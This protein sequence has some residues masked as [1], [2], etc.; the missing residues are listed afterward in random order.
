MTWKLLG[1]LALCAGVLANAGMAQMVTE[2]AGHRPGKA[3][4]GHMHMHMHGPV[5]LMGRHLMPEGKV[6]LGLQAGHMKMSGLR[7]GSTDIAATTLVT[8][9]P[10][11]FAGMPGQPPTLRVAPLWM[12][13][14]MLMLGAMYGATDKVT[15]MMMMPYIR[16]EMASLTYTGPA[17]TVP[18]G[19]SRMSAEGFGDLRIGAMTG[20]YEK[21][22][23][24]AVAGLGL[25][26]PTGSITKTGPML[27]PGGM[28]MVRR[29]G[30]GMQLGSGTYDLLPQ[31]SFQTG[32]GALNWGAHLSGV[33]RL[34]DNDEGY[35]LGN[36]AA[37]NLWASYKP[38]GWIDYTA[39]LETKT[40]D[41]IHGIDPAIVM[42]TPGAD[43]RNFG[44]E[45]VAL[46]L[47]TN[48]GPA[49]GIAKGHKI[50]LEIG[51]PVHQR[52]N[53]PRLKQD[54]SLRLGWRK[55]F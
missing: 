15:V 26:L 32:K 3:G 38:A 30:Y 40:A 45:Q 21:G 52:L 7:D 25:S 36:E 54:W 1:S 18:L 33:I 13:A 35:R 11:R 12:K 16:K 20:L 14:D 44:G 34:G 41:R 27:S 47:G 24:R 37:L 5:G 9:Y 49:R 8:R 17:G 2:H 22:R 51:M 6:M 55:A 10:N 42:P 4:G 31:L 50:N 29:M 23:S 48:I 28:R 53:G 39:R 46:Y 43:P 19:T